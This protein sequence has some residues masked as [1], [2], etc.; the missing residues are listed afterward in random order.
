MVVSFQAHGSGV[1][2]VPGRPRSGGRVRGVELRE[3]PFPG[4]ARFLVGPE[5]PQP[6][7]DERDL[8]RQS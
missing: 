7:D 3:P 4:L 2:A 8:N 6:D 5:F 1:L